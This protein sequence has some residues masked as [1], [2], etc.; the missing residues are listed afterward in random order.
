MALAYVSTLMPVSMAYSLRR[1][2][3][4]RGLRPRRA[5]FEMKTQ[6]NGQGLFGDQDDQKDQIKPGP[7]RQVVLAVGERGRPARAGIADLN[8][9]GDSFQIFPHR[10]AQVAFPGIDVEDK[11]ALFR[12]RATRSA[13]VPRR[14]LE[15]IQT[16][17]PR[18]IEGERQASGR[19]GDDL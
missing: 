7:F 3:R 17:L 16:R 4:T 13:L 18:L 12:L 19:L 2:G 5:P 10:A 6:M 8:S 9:A 11:G 14:Q 15:K 1:D